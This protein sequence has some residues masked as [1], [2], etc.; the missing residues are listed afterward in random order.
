M[1]SITMRNILLYTTN[2]N[3]Q[4][5]SHILLCHNLVNCFLKYKYIFEQICFLQVVNLKEARDFSLNKKFIYV[6]K[7]TYYRLVIPSIPT[8]IWAHMA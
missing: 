5:I 1:A 8:Y 2:E 6:F 4:V 3:W 7:V